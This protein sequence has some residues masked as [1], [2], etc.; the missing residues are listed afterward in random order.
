MEDNVRP[1]VSADA[2]DLE[3][4]KI[5]SALRPRT[6]A[7]F[8]GQRRVSEQLDTLLGESGEAEAGGT[9]WSAI[10]PVVEGRGP[11]RE[12]DTIQYHELNEGP[13]CCPVRPASVRPRWR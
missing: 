4:R 1:L 2:V 8:G 9:I 12:I 13:C 5:E 11:V 10:Q 6:L 7:E 3:E